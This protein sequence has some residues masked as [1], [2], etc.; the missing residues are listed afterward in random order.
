MRA[1]A[2]VV[3][4]GVLLL[5][6]V[7][8]ACAG[9]LAH[10]GEMTTPGAEAPTT[11]LVGVQG[12][13]PVGTATPD[14]WVAG[15]CDVRQFS[16]T[17]TP[18]PGQVCSSWEM[19]WSQ[20]QPNLT[21]TPNWNAAKTRVAYLDSEG[22][23]AWP[24]LQIFENK[25]TG[26]DLPWVPTGVPTVSYTAGTC[27]EVAPDYGSPV[28][29]D[30]YDRAVQSFC[31]WANTDDRVGGVGL[32]LGASC[33]AAN[34][35]SEASTCGADKQ[36][37]FERIVSGQAYKDWVKHAII[38]WKTYCPNKA[39][40]LATHLGAVYGEEGWKSAR[41]FMEWLKPP[42][43]TP[44]PALAGAKLTPTP[45]YG[46]A[47]RFNGLQPGD[48]MNYYWEKLAPWGRIQ[49]GSRNTDVG[50]SAYETFYS[51]NAIAAIPTAERVGML[52]DMTLSA[53]GP[54]RATNLFYQFS[55]GGQCG[56]DCYI[57]SWLAD[58]IT[59]T[60]GLGPT[61]STLA[62]VRF[63]G[64]ERPRFGDYQPRSDWPEEYTFLATLRESAEP[65]IYCWPTLYAAAQAQTASH[66]VPEV[67]AAAITPVVAESRNVLRYPAN[68]TIG[69]DF[70]DAWDSS[71]LAMAHLTYL[72]QG[73]D[74]LS[75][76]WMG[77]GGLGLVETT[78]TITKTNTG[79]WL[80]ESWFLGRFGAWLL[81]SFDGPADLEIDTEEGAEFL[82]F[83]SLELPLG[84]S[85]PPGPT[86]TATATASPTA[87]WT[88]SPT[89]TPT[90]TRTSSPT[91]TS[92]STVTQTP[93]ITQ[94]PTV[95]QTPT[96][97]LTPT[98]TRTPTA[99]P[100]GTWVT[101]TRTATATATRI[102]SE[103]PTIT[104][105]PTQTPTVTYTPSLTPT[106]T[107][108]STATETLTPTSTSTATHTPTATAT[109]AAIVG[110]NEGTG[111][112]V[113][114]Y[115]AYP[116]TAYG[117]A[118]HEYVLWDGGSETPGS[119]VRLWWPELAGPSSGYVLTAT[120]TLWSQGATQWTLLHRLQRG[121]DGQANWLQASDGE[122]WGAPGATSYETDRELDARA[123]LLGGAA[124]RET[125]LDVTADVQ[126]WLEGGESNYGW[127]LYPT[128]NG[129]ISLA[130]EIGGDGHPQPQYR[131]SLEVIFG[132]PTTPTPTLT[133]TL[134]PTVWPTL[135]PTPTGT[136]TPTVTPTGTPTNPPTA[137]PTS[138]PPAGV[139]LGEVCADPDRDHN[140]DGAID[141]RDRY[142]KLAN[143]QAGFSPAGWYL[144]FGA[145]D[146]TALCS[147]VDPQLTYRLPTWTYLFRNTPKTI[148]GRD[149][150]NLVGEAFEMPG[151]LSSG[152]VALCNAR[153]QLVDRLAYVWQGSGRCY[154]RW[155][156]GWGVR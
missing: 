100:T 78:Q 17:I 88:P 135:T 26:T 85:V 125:S 139:W 143:W 144:A 53:L 29:W 63:R 115:R 86:A 18:A 35:V 70:D 110:A 42:T 21:A 7:A 82:Y 92:T 34:V 132:M 81:N 67:C 27:D 22:L 112:S 126:A 121:W 89:F 102:P 152:A 153:G 16:T 72:D 133:P 155:G 104:L 19:Y 8:A 49:S 14:G 141:A 24:A 93:T 73:T 109:A 12:V 65:T 58:V 108:T 96:A 40:T 55:S 120:L 87:T 107:S 142:V 32:C 68:T 77:E 76:R 94:T 62:W 20:V 57:D 79:A 15:L 119:T 151:G 122:T 44:G 45:I 137:T 134:T 6:V 39:L 48:Q 38:T 46:V 149:L 130:T 60:A 23:G 1:R 41:Y 114:L 25:G 10:R 5:A 80:T 31:G 28:F 146:D 74:T 129:A 66:P 147:Q 9:A 124:W 91:A 150:V 52:R 64:A 98:I 95:T 2:W 103:T 83:F 97:T 128:I 47:D 106:P 33:E 84:I 111:A 13:L 50:G 131:A 156:T 136:R 75:V 118:E 116:D 99:T 30:A 113:T 36:Q 145:M 148:Y 154:V 140:L 4:A 138:T 51:R 54:G 3:I 123:A 69:I 127:G 61:D 59:G 11:N 43:A 37:E 71:V 56:W 101:P 90:A 117:A 105:T